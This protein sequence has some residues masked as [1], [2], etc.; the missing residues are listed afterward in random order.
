MKH[1]IV[2]L[3]IRELLIYNKCISP[4]LCECFSKKR[5]QQATE[6]NISC[7]TNIEQTIFLKILIFKC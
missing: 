5:K 7:K 4:I 2:N 6:Q 1:K 3:K